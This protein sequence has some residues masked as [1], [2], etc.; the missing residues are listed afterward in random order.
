M[1]KV[2]VIIFLFLLMFTTLCSA[3]GTMEI[4]IS[5]IYNCYKE[6]PENPKSAACIAAVA[7]GGKQALYDWNGVNQGNANDQHQALIPDGTLC[8]GGKT[9]F[10]GMNLARSDWNATTVMPNASGQYDFYWLATAPHTPKY[11]KFYLTNDAYNFNLPLKWSD[12][13]A[14]FCT[15]TSVTLLNGKY[16]MTCPLPKKTGRRILYVIWQRTD[17]TEAFYSCSDIILGTG[18][19]DG[20]KTTSWKE[21]SSITANTVLAPNTK[22]MFRLFKDGVEAEVDTITLNS[23]QTNPN[24]WPNALATYVNGKSTLVHIGQMNTTGQ[25]N[26]VTSATL[27]KIYVNTSD[28]SPYSMAIDLILPSDDYDYIYPNGIA[29]YKAGTKVLGADKRRYQCK[30]FPYSGWCPQSPFHYEPGKGIA[31]QDA[32]ILLN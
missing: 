16:K 30:P 29:N 2:H 11:F 27:N 20:G 4:P 18:S 3:H 22:V 31:W 28:I 26:P 14:P 23:S 9:Q 8:A 10:K 13:D 1:S 32:W 5:R 12:L 25:I 19:S 17:S 15:I 24:Q 6:G 21:L 7:D